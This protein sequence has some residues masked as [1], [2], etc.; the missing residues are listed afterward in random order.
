MDASKQKPG[1]TRVTGKEQ[2]YTPPNIAGQV[3]DKVLQFVTDPQERFW[4]EPSA[5]TGAFIEALSSRGFENVMAT[6]IEPHHQKI[7]QIDFL[8]WQP[9]RS[10]FITVGNPPF[11]RNNALSVPFFNHSANC[12]ELIAFIVPRSWRKWT[13]TNRLDL[14]FHKIH[15]EDLD[16]NY[17]DVSGQDNYRGSHLQTCLQIWR[18]EPNLR[19]RVSVRDNGFISKVSPDQA[20]IALRVFGYGCGRLEYDFKPIPNTTL[21]FLKINDQRVIPAM[22]SINF[23]HYSRNVSYTEALGL[24]EINHALNI[25]LLGHSDATGDDYL[26]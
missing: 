20:D 14:R 25:A 8:E 15:D 18:R 16:I 10:D 23:K 7:K 6:D 5:G 21:M 11:G 13:V 26:A 2:F 22:E 9:N 17:L 19:Q 3:V 1:N 4:L 12:S 24:A